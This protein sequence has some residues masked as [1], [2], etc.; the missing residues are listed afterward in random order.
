MPNAWGSSWG[1]SW[2]TS[3]DSGAFPTQYAGLK[4]YF[5]GSVQDLCLVAQAEAPVLVISN[6][7][8]NYGV[9]LV[10]TGDPDASPI[11]IKTADGVKAIRLKT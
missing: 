7:G 8:I 5:N 11:R 2:G 6:G 9:Y 3:W 1:S 4:A 10:D